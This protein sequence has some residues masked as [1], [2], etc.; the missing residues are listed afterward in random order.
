MKKQSPLPASTSAFN[1]HDPLSAR[2]DNVAI[3]KAPPRRPSKKN[4]ARASLTQ[5]PTIHERVIYHG[6]NI[7]RVFTLPTPVHTA[8]GAP[9]KKKMSLPHFCGTPVNLAESFTA[10]DSEVTEIMGYRSE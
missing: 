3:S 5:N 8:P 6:N 10:A 2:M 4:T 1:P 9:V 7:R